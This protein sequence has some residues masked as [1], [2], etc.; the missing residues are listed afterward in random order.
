MKN[1]KLKDMKNGWLVGNF[2][3]SVLKTNE[4]EVGI[5]RHPKS[6]YSWYAI[7]FQKNGNH[8][9]NFNQA[10]S[11]MRKLLILI[12]CKFIIPTFSFLKF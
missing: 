11:S 3:P 8:L 9:R 4:F 6:G 5:L 7:S 1:Y 12:E 10:R 2:L